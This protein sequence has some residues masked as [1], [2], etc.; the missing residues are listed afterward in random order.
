MKFL[1]DENVPGIIV[2]WLRNQGYECQWIAE[3]SPGSD[4]EPILSR[5]HREARILLTQDLDFADL[6]FR[7][8]QLAYSV[9]LLRM[10]RLRPETMLGYVQ[11]AIER[12]GDRLPHQFIVVAGPVVRV[13]PLPRE[14][15][16]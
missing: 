15:A 8:Q 12:I 10:G 4:D 6:V 14:K 1:A 11:Q 2:H 7:D 13:Q 9:M 16:Q 3:E 5:S